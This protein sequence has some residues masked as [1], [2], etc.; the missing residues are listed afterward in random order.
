MLSDIERCALDMLLDGDDTRLAI[1]R[2]QLATATVAE[3]IDTDSGFYTNFAV[4][5]AAPRLSDSKDLVIDDVC[6]EA[7]GFK[8]PVSFLLFVRD[9]ALAM[10]ECVSVGDDP[11][12]RGATIQRAYYLRPAAFGSP[13][14]IETGAR[15][16]R[17]VLGDVRPTTPRSSAS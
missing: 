10:L 4:P 3:R 15:Q 1:L 7:I 17:W 9:G 8:Y 16:L 14:L 13:Q 12:P 6:A 2:A 5:A 11:C